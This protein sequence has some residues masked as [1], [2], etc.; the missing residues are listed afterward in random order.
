MFNSQG[1]P[2]RE[3]SWT[4]SCYKVK[5]AFSTPV[6]AKKQTNGP[7]GTDQGFSTGSCNRRHAPSARVVHPPIFPVPPFLLAQNLSSRWIAPTMI[8]Y[9]VSYFAKAG[10]QASS[11]KVYLAA[12]RHMQISRTGPELEH[13][14]MPK[15]TPGWHQNRVSRARGS[16]PLCTQ[17]V[18]PR[19]MSVVF[20]LETRR[21]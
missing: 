14:K 9:F 4:K 7:P 20:G 18:V 21:H 19:P 12:I 1:P 16:F 6:C 5:G 17:S 11:I 2:T 10:L 3:R 15:N 8:C 13:N